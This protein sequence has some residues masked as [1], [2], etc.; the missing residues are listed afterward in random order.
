[1]PHDQLKEE[2]EFAW[3]GVIENADVRGKLRRALIVYMNKDIHDLLESFR[4]ATRETHRAW[5]LFYEKWADTEVR[6]I[7]A[8]LTE[9]DA[10][11][12][13]AA[14]EKAR[15][16]KRRRSSRKLASLENEIIL[17]VR[18]LGGVIDYAPA[19]L[20]RILARGRKSRSP[21]RV[22]GAMAHMCKTG[23]ARKVQARG[24]SARFVLLG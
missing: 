9:L 8:D 15:D 3:L 13:K 10:A 2:L 1:M 5:L 16:E 17:H 6:R 18:G 14:W 19:S 11:M 12:H 24:A 7:F 20:A 23:A 21:S 22:K 4:D